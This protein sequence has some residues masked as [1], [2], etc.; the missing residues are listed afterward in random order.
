MVSVNPSV[1]SLTPGTSQ[2]V[3]VEVTPPPTVVL[4][5]G[6]TIDIEAWVV[7][8]AGNLTELIG[9]IRK[10]DE[11]LI[12]LGPPGERPF[13]EKEIRVSPYPVV[14]GE[15]AEVCVVLEN[16]TD[17]DQNV[18]V[19][20]MMSNFGIGLPFATI[21][22]T[23]G[24][25]PQ[26][27]FLPA[28]STVVV[29]IQFL[30]PASG[31]HCLAVKLTMANGY[32]TISRRNL[33]V[34][35]LLEPEVPEEVPIAVANPTATTAD[36]DLVVDNT[37]LGW[38][39]WVSPT[40]L[41]GVGPDGS[42]VRTAV[43][44][45]IPPPGLLGTNCHIDLLAYINGQLI[46]G[47]R[48]ID[49]PPTAPPID[50]PPWAEREIRVSPDPP[51]VGQPAQVCVELVNPTPVDQTVDVTFAWADFGAG[52]GFTDIQT[53]NGSVIPAHGK[54]IICIPWTPAPGGTLHRCLRVQIHQ[55][56]YH[57]VFSQ[58]NVDLVRF[59]LGIIQ[60]P[61]GLFDLPPFV[62]HNPSSEPVSFFFHVGVVG[63]TGASVEATPIT[64][65][66]QNAGADLALEPGEEFVLDPGESQE[67]FV[68]ITADG[69]PQ[70]VGDEHYVDVLPYAEG[71]ALLV[72]GIQSGVRYVLEEPRV[73]LPLV[74]RGSSVP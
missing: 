71:Q 10:I 26:P 36:I 46:G 69:E 66:R 57:D 41:F 49:R 60:V 61:G 27:V 15:P 7:D 62:L 30:P 13:A 54:L 48:K 9:G 37:C 40:V 44:T 67:F 32:E 1:F 21:P 42:D 14:A 28:H 38:M 65:P 39:A 56:G 3:T 35:E 5:S 58:R 52:I 50:E 63:L 33:D 2:M 68:R 43:L 51:L 72:D 53:V 59:P 18:T 31:H 12:P 8:Q 4:G 23:G 64:L 74:V 19:E 11:P 24:A 16:N 20:F 55:E 29:C 47:V 73:Y 17:T 6:C 22:T 70:F 25:N 45:V 34:A